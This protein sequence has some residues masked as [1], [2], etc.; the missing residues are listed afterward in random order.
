LTN[1]DNF[2]ENMTG[3]YILN[4]N[5]GF[6]NGW[7]S[8]YA[9][10]FAGAQQIYFNVD[11]PDAS[12]ITPAQKAYIQ[13]YVDSFE[14]AMNGANFQDTTLG[15]RRF[16]AVN[17][18]ADFMIMNEISR[19]NEA[20]RRNMYMYKDKSKKL[21]PGPLWA[22]DLAWNNTQSCTSSKDTG[23]AYNFGGSCPLE[24]DL[25]P[26]WFSKLTT[27]TAFM[28]DLKCLYT[29]Y[30]NPGNVLDTSKIFFIIDSIN[31][32]L[33]AQTAIARNFTQWPIWGTPIVNE[34]TPMAANYDEEVANLKQ[35]IRK[36]IIWLDSKWRLANGCPA[37]L[38]IA[39]VDIANQLN[40]FPNP[41]NDFLTVRFSGKSKNGFK[42]TIYSIQGGKL[43][44]LNTKDKEYTFNISSYPKGI[45]LLNVNT[46]KGSITRKITKD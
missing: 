8:N 16:G 3:G 27:D 39:D 46:D 23:W 24:N 34:P 21:R 20:Y 37:P 33:N 13:S 36:R 45:Y 10:P 26:F 5:E 6:S 7:I 12:D 41:A 1:L 17:G 42:A 40:I 44:S 2:G 25:A 43:H 19:N 29:D 14:N 31:I 30:R 15:W 11:Y 28:K 22:F 32:R 4:V 35:F 18:F 9:P 38:A